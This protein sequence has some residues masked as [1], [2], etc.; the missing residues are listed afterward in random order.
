MVESCRAE[1][2]KH[3]N[4]FKGTR[5]RTK[6]YPRPLQN[7]HNKELNVNI[8]PRT[9]IQGPPLQIAP[10]K[11]TAKLTSGNFSLLALDIDVRC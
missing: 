11:P 1:Q 8:V 2:V 10:S 3:A 9:S 5:A 6:G 4:G 7:H